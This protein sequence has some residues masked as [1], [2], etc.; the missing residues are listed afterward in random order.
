MER[1][2]QRPTSLHQLVKYMEIALSFAPHHNSTLLKQVPVDIRTGN[3]SV[4][5]EAN[6]NELSESAGVVVSLSLGIA[7]RFQ[8]W[9][10]LKNLTFQKTKSALRIEVGRRGRCAYRH[11]FAM[12]LH[13]CSSR[14]SDGRHR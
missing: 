4:R 6:A 13:G 1:T 10:C 12:P 8:D 2:L 3:A 11:V 14:Q 7:E 9:I 5:R